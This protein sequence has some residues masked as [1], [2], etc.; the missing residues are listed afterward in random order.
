[1]RDYHIHIGQFEEVYYPATEVFDAVFADG[2]VDSIMFSSTTSCVPSVKYGTV[3]AEIEAA[4]KL[5]GPK[6]TAPLFWFIPD[7]IPQGVSIE[8]EMRG[9]PYT[10]FK[11]HP[12]AQHWDFQSSL[13]VGTLHTIFDYAAQHK[14]SI[15]IHTG[16]SGVD[17]PDRF[18]EFFAAYTGVKFIL[19]HSRPADTTIVMLRKFPHVYCD[20]AFAPEETL[21]KITA[22]GF[23]ERIIFGT[24]F[25]VTHYFRTKYPPPG[26]NPAVTLAEQY[27]EDMEVLQIFNDSAS[28]FFL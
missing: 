20:S 27:A 26:K 19:A 3:S 21:R 18:A 24:D 17:S 10:G 5:F 16:E 28:E 12:F 11:L 15:Q 8:T 2:V 4:L 7:Y 25:P 22:A 23:S 9:L 14:L 6:K 1:M 13:H